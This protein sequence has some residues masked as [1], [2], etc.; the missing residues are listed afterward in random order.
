MPWLSKWSYPLPEEDLLTWTFDHCNYDKNTPIYIDLENPSRTLSWTQSRTVVRQLIAGF[1]AAGLRP[2]DC[3]MI[4]SFNDIMYCMLFLALIGAGGIFTGSNPAYTQYEI[5][6]HAKT[7]KV[8]YILVEP[9]LLPQILKGS[10]NLVDRKDIFIFNIRGQ[11]CPEGFRSW[12]WLLEHGETDWIRFNGKDQC[13][14]T[15]MARLTTSGTTG[16]PKMAV[17]SH[18]NA[19]SW[20]TMAS[21][22]SVPPWQIRNLFPL[23]LFHVATVP[24]VHCGPLR[25]GNI[26][27]IMRRFELESF[28][29]AV[30]KHKISLLG[31]VPPLVIA[32]INSPLRHKYSLRSVRRIGCGAAPLDKDSGEKLKDLCAPGCTFTQVLGST[33]TT[34]VFTLFYYPD[35]DDTGSVGNT[36]FPNS[37]VKLIDDDGNDVT[38]YD[39]QGEL[40]VRGPSIIDGYFENQKA[41]EDSWDEDGFYKT[42]DIVYCDGKTKKWYIVDRKKE[43]IK[44]RG[45]QVAPP[46]VEGVLLSHP[47]IIDVA[48][49]GL[50]APAN[51]DAERPRAYVVRAPGS[52]ITEDDVHKLVAER[53]AAYKKLTGGVKFVQEV[54]KSAS[55]KILKRVLR[56]EAQK[57]LASGAGWMRPKL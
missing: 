32:I 3:V 8:K 46:E 5:A 28:L 37:D 56:E 43:L 17:Q 6:H 44:V 23:P 41:N 52:Q 7:A 27:Y 33:E 40:C 10:E 38:D 53:L 12:E 13:R 57:E 45:F 2:G 48:V 11:A 36:W 16:P 50:P 54:P 29:A 24:A 22:I 26:A 30:E 9:E 1:H 25:R 39:V 14:R 20:F 4:A 34:G 18:Y 49:I 21:E 31:M 15:A 42:G 51:S 35:E 47:D 19:T 55:G